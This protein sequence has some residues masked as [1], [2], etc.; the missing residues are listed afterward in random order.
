MKVIELVLFISKKEKKCTL[1]VHIIYISLYTNNSMN[2]YFFMRGPPVEI[3]VTELIYFI[4]IFTFC[5]IIYLKTKDIYH[6]S[7]H[8]GIKYFR[9]IFL[10]FAL[11]FFF[12]LLVLFNPFAREVFDMQLP[13]IFFPLVLTLVT[14]FSTLAICSITLTSIFK[15]YQDAEHIDLIIHGISLIASLTIFLTRSPFYLILFQTLLF[16]SSIVFLFTSKKKAH[17]QNRITYTLLFVFWIMNSINFVKRLVPREFKI[18]LYILSA[19]VFLSVFL[20]VHKRLPG[21]SFEKKEKKN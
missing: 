4:V 11:A 12:R 14:Y 16:L 15:R 2:N 3:L 8:K 9:D 20:R 1:N 5:V 19:F 17:I 7:K 21:N 13:F 6:L 10:F 18:P